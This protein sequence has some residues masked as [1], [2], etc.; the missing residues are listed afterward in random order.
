MELKDKKV[1]VVGTGRSGL[2][3][4]TLLSGHGARILLLDQN[5]KTSAEAV[6]TRLREGESDFVELVIG[7][8]PDGAEKTLDFAVLSPAVPMDSPVAKTLVKAGVPVL[9]ELELAYRFDRGDVIAITGTNGK[10]TTT[11]LT[12]EIMKAYKDEV[13]VV[14]NIGYS[15]AGAADATTERS[16]SVAEVSSFQL[17]W[18]DEFHPRVSAILNITPDHLDRHY[19]IQNYAAVK[20]KIARRQTQDEVCVLNYDDVWLRP[21][22]ECLCPAKAVWFSSGTVLRDGFYLRD[23]VIYRARNGVSQTLLYVSEMQLVGVCNAENVMAAMAIAEAY[24]V[25]METIL[26]VIRKFPPVKD[27]IEFVGE[28]GGVRYYNDSKATNPD[29]AIQGIKAMD[30]PTV[31]IGG[32][33]D[34]H[35]EYGEWIDAFGGKVKE[36][37]LIGQTRE[38]IAA[39]CRERGFT[40]I[41][42][43]DTFE[44]CLQYCTS[45]ADKGDAVLL[46]PACASWGM[47]P[48]YEVRGDM[49]RDYVKGL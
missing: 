39:A 40:S 29:A 17:E 13:Y 21:F 16:V 46:S 27:R 24:G 45:V 34:K 2:G 14:G 19:T 8:L 12:G 36:L 26:D 37:V 41:H 5:T 3:A 9:S 23:G 25:P 42:M 30:R 22:G 15:Y 11:T 28:K 20:E 49:F 48:N 31:L 43:C 47:F 10:T 33:Y 32:G 35:N 6:M 44:E 18:A 1:L 7:D 38:A 4:V